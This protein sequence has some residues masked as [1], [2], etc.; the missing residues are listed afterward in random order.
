MRLT[1]VHRASHATI[2]ACRFKKTFPDDPQGIAAA[3]FLATLLAS[4]SCY[5]LDT[6]RR[7]MQLKSTNYSSVID[8]GI[9]IVAK[10]GINGLFRVSD[11][12]LLLIFIIKVE[13]SPIS[14]FQ[15]FIPN[16]IKNAPNKSIQLTT[17]DMLKKTIAKSE[18]ALNEEKEILK[19]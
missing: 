16:A 5:P 15:G 3:S 18:T 6:I 13:S 7:Q 8:A 2:D 9:G 10:D 14:V 19:V 1:H 11:V 17:Y 4:G 12:I